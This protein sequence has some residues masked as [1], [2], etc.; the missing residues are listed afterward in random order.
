MTVGR[1]QPSE[2]ERADSGEASLIHGL[3]RAIRRCAG[4]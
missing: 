4:T 1:E 2:A 3:S